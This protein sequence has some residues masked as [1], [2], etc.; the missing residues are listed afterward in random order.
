MPPKTK[1]TNGKL[2][3]V[4]FV[5]VDQKLLDGLERLRQQQSAE[6]RGLSIST[7]D[8]VRSI[9]WDVIESEEGKA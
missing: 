6:S 3:R 1:P 9:L 4:L 2:N 5:R 7:A 8:V